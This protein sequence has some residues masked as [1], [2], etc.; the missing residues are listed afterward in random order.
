MLD[1]Q[2][3]DSA[4]LH[5]RGAQVLATQA[6][7]TPRLIR[8]NNRLQSVYQRL[9][10]FDSAI[11]YQRNN[12][13]IYSTK[14]DTSN[15]VNSL[16]ALIFSNYQSGQYE[17]AFHYCIRLE[18]LVSKMS[19]SPL[20]KIWMMKG[21]IYYDLEDYP[22]SEYCFE[23][24]L[25]VSN[26]ESKHQNLRIY[27]GMLAEFELNRKN[28]QMSVSLMDTVIQ[29]FRKQNDKIQI[30]YSGMYKARP[31]YRMGKIKE[32]RN[33]LES[34]EKILIKQPSKKKLI[35]C[36]L[37]KAEFHTKQEEYQDAV[38]CLLSA[39][40]L[41][42]ENGVKRE[43][44]KA[45]RLLSELYDALGDDSQ[46]LAHLKEYQVY[47]DL[48]FSNKTINSIK[49]LEQAYYEELNALK[50]ATFIS[51]NEK[52]DLI[53]A[54]QETSIKLLWVSIGSA[55]VVMAIL[56]VL[57][58]QYRIMQKKKSEMKVYQ[59]VL[60][61][62][63]EE[64]E[65]IARDLHDGV[66]SD[67]ALLK[68]GIDRLSEANN[69]QQKKLSSEVTNI[70]KEIR[71]ISHNLS[72]PTFADGNFEEVVGQYVNQ[73]S[74]SS[75]DLEIIFR[76]YPITDWSSISQQI[77]VTLYRIIQEIVHNTIK[78][79]KASKLEIQIV[80]HPESINLISEDNGTGVDM[81]KVKLGNGL[82]NI[83]SRVKSLNGDWQVDSSPDLYTSFNINIPLDRTL[84][85]SQIA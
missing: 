79:S 74:E 9:G 18:R 64:R 39:I 7:D 77:Q 6:L 31:L 21:Y 51:D 48:Y 63:E 25:K 26:A 34:A 4:I 62:Q 73:F 14:M 50:E 11:I 82:R 70:S 40:K 29:E 42:N 3:L 8:M 69:H 84:T 56:L 27:Q 30:A 41:Q 2:H 68:M 80:H 17:V 1:L 12:L 23:Q 75:G 36:Y 72:Q 44:A 54:N 61:T 47:R 76:C 20:D 24:M 43:I 52:K 19:E 59:E 16:F 45:H 58:S 55:I 38:K 81:E 53:I 67:L 15:M 35:E 49:H 66:A 10:N 33:L 22:S 60:K 71:L 32:A 13:E 57:W 65:R 85:Q 28:Y 46:A 83:E 37:I 78:H 5:F